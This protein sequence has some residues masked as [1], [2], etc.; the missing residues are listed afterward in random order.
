MML[1]LYSRVISKVTFA[2]TALCI[3]ATLTGDA[4]AKDKHGMPTYA[5]STKVRY[6]RTTSYSHM[7][8]EPGAPGRL[9]AAGTILKY[10]KT[11][12]SAAADWSRLPLGTKFVI[13]SQPHIVYV[14][15]DY[16]SALVG[17]NTVDIFKPTLAKMRSWGTRKLTIKIIKMGSFKES[18]RLLRG[19]V[20]YPHCNRMYKD[21][22]RKYPHL[23]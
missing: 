13:T 4:E 11:L 7:E 16:G 14:V 21:I 8:K 17:T 19:R 1:N 2:L 9:N 23:K 12:R 3:A 18:I 5:D 6:V 22:R 10:G 20:K 15:D